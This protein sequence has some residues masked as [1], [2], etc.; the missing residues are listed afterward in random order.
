MT[1]YEFIKTHRCTGTHTAV[2]ENTPLYRKTHRCTGK[3]T[4]VQELFNLTL[5]SDS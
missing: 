3:H 1:K 4:A 2:Q 5:T